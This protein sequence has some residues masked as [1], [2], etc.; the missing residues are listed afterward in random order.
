M[1]NRWRRR[2]PAAGFNDDFEDNRPPRRDRGDRGDRDRGPRGRGRDRDRGDRELGA[3][4]IVG[5]A[6]RWTGR[7]QGRPRSRAAQA[8]DRGDLQAR[9]GSA[10]PGHQ[11]GSRHQGPDAEHLHQHRRPLSRADAEPQPRRR[12]AKD[13]GPRRPPPAPRDH[14][15]PQPAE[16]RRLH[17]PHRRHRPRRPRTAQRPRLPPAPLAGRRQADQARLR[18]GR[19]LP[20]IGHDHPDDPRHLHQ[21]HRHHLGGRGDGVRARQRVPADRHA[22][23]RQPHPL[24][25]EHRTALPQVRRRGRDRRRSTRSGSRCRSAGRSS[26]SRPKRSSPST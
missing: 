20:R 19:D 3:I 16:G 10:R 26:S 23:V 2:R 15:Y 1:Q 11:G 12:V 25:R 9:A 4:V 7:L 8:E 21:R 6:H 17:R 22:E 5:R 24:L 14:D 13:R 18:P